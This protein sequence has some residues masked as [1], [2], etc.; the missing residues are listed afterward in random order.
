MG[1]DGSGNVCFYILIIVLLVVDLLCFGSTTN[2]MG[3]EILPAKL[4]T[5]V[6]YG[7]GPARISRALNIGGK[8][9][10]LVRIIFSGTS[11]VEGSP[12]RSI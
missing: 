7:K 5:E 2:F 6:I 1:T 11:V 8:F 10:R 3:A 9:S 4:A 12:D